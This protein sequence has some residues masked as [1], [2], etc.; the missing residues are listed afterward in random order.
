[1]SGERREGGER[2]DE[3]T[4]LPSFGTETELLITTSDKLTSL[5]NVLAFVLLFIH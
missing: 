2:N 4:S 3:T 1:M 5:S